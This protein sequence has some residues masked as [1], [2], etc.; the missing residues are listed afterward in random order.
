MLVRLGFV[1]VGVFVVCLG[2]LFWEMKCSFLD[3][4]LFC[5]YLL[6][7]NGEFGFCIYLFVF[8]EVFLVLDI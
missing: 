5:I 1:E 4:C 3:G 6:V 2:N 7:L 8:F